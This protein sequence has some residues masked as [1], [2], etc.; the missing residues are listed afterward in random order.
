MPNK[1]TW[2]PINTLMAFGKF[3][4]VLFGSLIIFASSRKRD[5]RYFLSQLSLFVMD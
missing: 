1:W 4:M 2:L 5:F 3:L